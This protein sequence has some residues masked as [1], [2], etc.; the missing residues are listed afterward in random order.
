MNLKSRC[1]LVGLFVC[2]FF[3]V[4]SFNCRADVLGNVL[5][6]NANLV[7]RINLAKIQQAP[8]VKLIKK[9]D[10][11]SPQMKVDK[12]NVILKKY[13]LSD[14][15]FTE[16]VM[17]LSLNADKISN[18]SD[19]LKNNNHQEFVL[20]VQMTKPL[21]LENLKSI[22]AALARQEGRTKIDIKMQEKSGIKFLL[23]T[24][25]DPKTK[26][27]TPPIALTIL[28]KDKILIAGVSGSLINAVKRMKSGKNVVFNNE[29]TK[30]KS[31]IPKSADFYLVGYLSNSLR[32]KLGLVDKVVSTP[33]KIEQGG[34]AGP[35]FNA[36]KNINAVAIQADFSKNLTVNIASYF[37]DKGSANATQGLLKQFLPIFKFQAMMFTKGVPLPVINSITSSLSKTR[38]GVKIHF[39]FTEGDVKGIHKIIEQNSKN[40]QSLLKKDVASS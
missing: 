18:I 24:D 32:A 36:L 15:D 3:A 23:I 38:P 21:S 9:Y 16:M 1:F 37:T 34:N 13:G 2:S 26:D 4:A 19:A 12:T 17:G 7:A 29:L 30:L 27:Q 6:P 5:M 25:L 11:L 22:A 39:T 20:G 31:E 33:K 14:Q 28:T 40:Q 8:I 10:T 35:D